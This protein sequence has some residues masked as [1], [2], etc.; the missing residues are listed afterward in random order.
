MEEF[1]VD[2][3]TI[4]DDEGKEY[5]MEILSRFEFEGQEYIALTPAGSDDDELSTEVNLLRIAV[6]NNEEVLEAI[7][8]EDELQNAFDYLM[9][10][11]FEDEDE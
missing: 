8:D 5:E 3:I 4:T 6:E 2:F 11:V 1:G 10:Q 7:A 9:N